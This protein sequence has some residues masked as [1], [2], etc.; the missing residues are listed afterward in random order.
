MSQRT[1]LASLFLL[2]AT[3]CTPVTVVASQIRGHYLEARTCEVYTG[4]GFANAEIGLTGK[5]AVMAWQIREG[6]HKG[7]DLQGLSVVVVVRA[8][9]T[10]AFEGLDDASSIKSMIV[11]DEKATDQQ[12]EALISFAKEH[13]GKAGKEV[14]CIRTAP[15]TMELNVSQL[16]GSLQAGKTVQMTT[17]K[18]RPED[19]ICSNESAYYP[20]LAKLEN[21]APGVVIDGNVS[22]RQLGTSWSI[23]GSRSAYMAT[24][25]YE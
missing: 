22:A 8:T 11:V 9:E 6:Q 4:P 13:A 3:L 17:R 5:N 24:F 19:C 23:P 20:P 12:R 21:F 14:A 16:R 18:T 7:I 25:A 2:V 15:I 1:K 10:L